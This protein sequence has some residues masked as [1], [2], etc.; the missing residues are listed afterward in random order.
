MTTHAE[1]RARLL[2]ARY[3]RLVLI[4]WTRDGWR[5]QC[6]CGNIAVIKRNV[7][8]YRSCGC[9]RGRWSHGRALER[10]RLRKAEKARLAQGKEQ[11]FWER[12]DRRGNDE[13]WPW[14]RNC[15]KLGYGQGSYKGVYP[16][17]RAA[18]AI[19]KGAIPS[20]LCVRHTCDNPACCNPDH[21]I[22]GTQADNTADRVSRNRS[23]R[24]ERHGSAR[25]TEV[26]V[27]QL[28]KM[29]VDGHES[30]ELAELLGVSRRCITDALTGRKWSHIPEGI[31]T[32]ENLRGSCNA[33]SDETK[34]AIAAE[35]RERSRSV[36]QK[37]GV[38]ESSVRKIWRLH[39]SL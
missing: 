16:A 12:V 18:Y 25:L 39:G 4:E 8:N 17:H 34:A 31:I 6:D 7:S 30:G 22:L 3:G 2:G 35:P 10:S 27:V 21:L 15:S 20:G 28:R 26:Q 23:A 5:C 33:I 14:K 37:Y 36:A 29:Y 9:L 1:S 11:L 19:A 32:Q 24:G 38:A 13:C